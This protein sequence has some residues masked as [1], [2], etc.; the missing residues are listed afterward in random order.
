[1]FIIL[2]HGMGGTRAHPGYFTNYKRALK[3]ADELAQAEVQDAL[4]A[5]HS[6]WGVYADVSEVTLE[7]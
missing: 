6:G 7:G 2:I 5:G 3:R 4:M 1:M